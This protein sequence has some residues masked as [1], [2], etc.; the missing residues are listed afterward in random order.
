MVQCTSCHDPHVEDADPQHKVFLVKQNRGGAIC[1]TCHQLPYWQTNPSSHQRSPASPVPPGAAPGP[2]ATIADSAC[3]SCHA[4]HDAGGPSLVRGE[5]SQGDDAACLRCHDGRVARLDVAAEV[6]KPFS[7]GAPPAGPSGHDAAEGPASLARTLPENRPS[8][9]RHATCVDCHDPH[10]SADRSA[11]APR[12]PGSLAGA[13]G[14]DRYG[15]R[16]QP[17][18]FEYEI[19]FKCHADSANQPQRSGGALAGRLPKRGVTEVNLRLAFDATAA[20]SHPVLG[21][22]RNPRVPGLVAPLTVASAIYCSDCH[23]ADGTLPRAFGGS[24][25]RTPR[26]PHGSTHEH[27]LAASYS[28]TDLVPESPGAY[29]LC[30]RCHRR[31]VLLSGGSTFSRPVSGAGARESLHARHLQGVSPTAC[32]TCHNAHGI[33]ALAGTPTGN[34]HLVDFDRNVVAASRTRG[35]LEYAS[36]GI[37]GSCTMSCHGK[38]HVNAGY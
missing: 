3:S 26:G 10:A 25:G 6:S 16:V 18:N 5:R 35:L 7:H 8:Q 30:Y 17:V 23:S 36:T 11:V 2:Y 22:G 21:P 29:A 14:I 13:W 15:M 37:G 38:D 31:E 1:L 27:L 19:C 24:Q 9:P 20:S 34:A 12:A 33:S 28:I 32:S 4:M